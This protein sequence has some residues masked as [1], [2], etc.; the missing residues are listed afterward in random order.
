MKTEEHKRKISDTLK[1]KG[2]KPPSRKGYKLSEESKQKVGLNGFHYGML[3]KKHSQK[4]IEKIR[5]S[6]IKRVLEGKNNFWQGGKSF[7]PYT[8]DWTET[9]RRSI[10][11]RDHYTCQ[12]CGREG[13]P[14]HHKD[15]DKKNCNPE[16]LITLCNNCHSKTNGNRKY[17]IN[18]FLKLI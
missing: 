4:T 3:G 16:N 14:I 8:I 13:Y 1:R 17:W 11:E 10:R 5:E 7:E 18:Y 2:I 9:L 6:H 12:I 15:Y